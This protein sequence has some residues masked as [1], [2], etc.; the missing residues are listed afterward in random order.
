MEILKHI[1]NHTLMITTF[2]LMMMMFVDYINV[3]SRGRLLLMIR[4][5]GWRQYFIS[6]FLGASPG[7]LGA[8]MNVSFYIHGFISFGAIVGG[9]V[10]TCGDEAFVMFA[11]FPYQTLLIVFILFVVGVLSGFVVDRIGFLKKLVSTRECNL[12]EFHDGEVR[13]FFDLKEIVEHFKK[14]SFGRFS[15]LLSLGLALYG[16]I[17]GVLGP[18]EWGWERI[19]FLVLVMIAFYIISSVSEHYLEDHVWNHIIKKHLFRI[20]AW[21]F[22]ALAL[23]N[24]GL[25]YWDLG[26]FVQNHMIWVFLLACIIGLIPDSGPHLIFVMLYAQGLIPFSVLL[27]SCIVQDGHGVL[28]LLSYSLRETLLVKLLNLFFGFMVGGACYM[29]G[30]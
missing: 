24:I 18:S 27:T 20:A 19:T 13:R 5:R 16:F 23:V 28:P 21:T 26:P 17:S 8:F 6:S 9:M 11:M 1:V 12:F 4:G 29:L 7:C 3:M 14:I 22:L 25:K 2:V 30:F 15:L 10:A